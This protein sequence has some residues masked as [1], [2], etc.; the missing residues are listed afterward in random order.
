[1]RPSSKPRTALSAWLAVLAM[2]GAAVLV[3]ATTRTAHAASISQLQQQISSQQNR[4]NN[5]SGQV[6][7]AQS[8][9]DQL[10][11][12]IASLQKKLSGIQADLDAKRA[13][14]IKLEVELNAARKRLAELQALEARGEQI[15]TQQVVNSYES[16]QPDLVNVVLESNGFQDLLERVQYVNRIQ[17]QNTRVV[18]RVKRQRRAVTAQAIRLGK[19]EQHQQELTVAVLHERNSLAGV[20]VSLLRKRIA[21]AQLKDQKAGQLQSAKDKVSNLQD[22]LSKAQQAQAAQ[23]AQAAGVPA[24]A[25]SGTPAGSSG[26]FTFPLPKDAASPPGTWSPDDGVDISAPGD[27]PE[28]AVCS[29]TIVLHGIGGFGPDAPVIHCDSPVAGYN[30]VYY[31]HAGPVNQLPVG[32]HVSAGQVMSSVGPGIVGISTGPHLEIGFC[33][34]SGS[35]VGPGSAGAM[36]SLLQ[37]S[38]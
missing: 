26:G 7:A 18:E 27:T 17:R 28:F 6:G 16:D 5:L 24:S 4:I 34:D 14:L 30:D 31:G 2:A 9:L 35:P 36:M 20:R 23:A 25:T 29:G 8:R 13:Q 22:Q 10:N 21:V 37:A 1:M 12:S 3:I 33:D 19:L 38:Y 15:L 11:G 32:T